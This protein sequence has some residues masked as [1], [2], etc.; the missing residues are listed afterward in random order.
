MS[1]LRR[2][3]AL[4]DL[5]ASHSVSRSTTL[6]AASVLPHSRTRA[7]FEDACVGRLRRS[8]RRNGGATLNIMRLRLRLRQSLE[9]ILEAYG[10]PEAFRS[11]RGTAQESSFRA[12]SQK[13]LIDSA[14][15]SSKT[16]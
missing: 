7:I 6:I 12:P 5:I 1:I 13:I 8:T 4:H 9:K 11:V 15:F 3:A 10:K 2:D 16:L 14:R